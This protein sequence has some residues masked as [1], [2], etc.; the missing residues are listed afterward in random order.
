MNKN[1]CQYVENYTNKSYYR[2]EDENNEF[3]CIQKCNET[4]P[5]CLECVKN[6][7]RNVSFL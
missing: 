2:M 1:I 3:S 6:K 7:C 4:Y 5:H